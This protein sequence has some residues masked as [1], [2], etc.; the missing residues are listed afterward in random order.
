MRS[1]A[2]KVLLQMNCKLGG[3]PWDAHLPFKKAGVL[4]VVGVDTFVDAK[5]A[6]KSKSKVNGALV[7]SYDPQATKW[8]RY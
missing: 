4:M 3:S 7:A 5:T 2:T 6:G 8:F 1:V